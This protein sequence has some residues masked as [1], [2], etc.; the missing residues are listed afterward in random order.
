MTPPSPSPPPSPA[1][2][3]AFLRGLDKRARLFATVQAGDAGLADR[4]RA[5]VATV[6]GAEAGQWPLAQWPAQYWRLLLAAPSLRQ[7]P[8]PGQRVPL[9]GIARLP[10][11]RR[12]AVLLHLVAGLDDEAAASALGLGVAAYQDTIRDSL[13]LDAL[14]RPDLDVWRAWR[15]AVERELERAPEPP[16]LPARP[17]PPPE[18][19]PRDEPGAPA[20]PRGVRWLWIGVA[21]CAL[22]FVASFFV[23]P[24]GREVVRQWMSPIKVEP[25][26]PAAAPKARFDAADLALHPD[27]ELLVAPREAG[28]ARQ[29]PMLAWLA[30]TLA[31]APDTLR[32][33]VLMA[34]TVSAPDPAGA[35]ERRMRLWD[36]LPHDVRGARRRAWQAWRT[37]PAVERVR[38]R[39]VAQRFQ[40]MSGEDRDALRTRFE[41]Q[42]PDARNGWWLG[43]ERGRD[44]PRIAPLFAYVDQAERTRLLQLLHEATPVEI[45]A[46]ARLSQSTPPEARAGLR[47][48]LLAQPRAQR[49]QWM[50]ERLQR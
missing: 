3:S 37:L 39:M 15:A 44:W 10:P 8:A 19:A 45:D 18:A 50:L 12:A 4:A 38:L 36:R 29:L 32:L 47:A 30:D 49:V 31:S 46:L 23:L 17:A 16:P 22:A 42:S 21:L 14:G 28:Y 2:V 48:E 34:P 13:P 1:A 24:Q 5:V 6:F 25:L 7:P 35:A 43:P 27:R 11:D 9:P 33:P 26:P 20:T 41:A 40:Q